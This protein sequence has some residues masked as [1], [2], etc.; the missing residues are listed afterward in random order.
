MTKSV[1]VSHP[2]PI[3]LASSSP[4]RR[5]LL[6]RLGLPFSCSTPAIDE[7]PLPHETT[8][9]LALRLA[10]LKARVVAQ[11]HPGAWVIGSDQVADLFGAVLGKP[12]N[13]E[14]ALAQLQLMRGNLV[15][16]HTA[17]C[18]MRDDQHTTLSVLTTVKF[19]DLPDA[20]LEAYLHTEQPYDCAGSAKVEGLGISLL[21]SVQSDDPT[22]LIGL[23]LIALSG[24]LRNAGF[25]LPSQKL[26]SNQ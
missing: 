25:E 3:I 22:A 18:F 7:S 4:Y 12:G 11:Q 15:H 14:R 9:A 5:E 24:L 26:V 20:I 2:A 16:F 21:E 1:V 10:A 13:F 17:L 8:L 6:A 23:P 19:R